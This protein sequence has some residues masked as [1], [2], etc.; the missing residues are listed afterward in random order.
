MVWHPVYLRYGRNGRKERCE[1]GSQWRFRERFS[2]GDNTPGTDPAGDRPQRSGRGGRPAQGPHAATPAAPHRGLLLPISL[3][4]SPQ[5]RLGFRGRVLVRTGRRAREAATTRLARRRGGGPG[6]T[7]PR[8]VQHPPSLHR[9]A[10]GRTPALQG[11]RSLRGSPRFGPCLPA[12]HFSRGGNAQRARSRAPEGSAAP[13]PPPDGI[14]APQLARWGRM[15][16][17]ALVVLQ[18]EPARARSA[19]LTRRKRPARPLP[20]SCGH[21]RP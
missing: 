13:D 7:G 18:P 10:C 8:L 5:G 16:P 14:S 4:V 11:P 19:L 15:G 3:R 21:S 17:A 1:Q 12:S 9:R 6:G 20:R 2:G